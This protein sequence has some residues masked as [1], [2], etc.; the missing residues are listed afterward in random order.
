MVGGEE[1]IQAALKGYLSYIDKEAFQD[2]SDTGFKYSGEK[3]LE[4][5]ANL[6]NPK[7]TQIGCA[8]EKCPDDY[9]YS[10]YC[11]TNQK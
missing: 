8:I 5:Y 4:A 10:V 3:N 6:V 2:V 1:T 7:T 11:I 9:Y